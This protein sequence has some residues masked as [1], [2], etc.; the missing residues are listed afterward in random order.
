MT[1]KWFW[2][3]KG[4]KLAFNNHCL[5]R[6]T[7]QAKDVE[8]PCIRDPREAWHNSHK[9]WNIKKVLTSEIWWH[10]AREQ[11]VFFR[12]VHH[13]MEINDYRVKFIFQNGEWNRMSVDMIKVLRKGADLAFKSQRKM[14]PWWWWLHLLLPKAVYYPYLGGSNCPPEFEVSVLFAF[15]SFS[16]AT[17]KTC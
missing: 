4:V 14:P 16:S 6:C 3:C 11:L 1:L 7:K 9:H 17:E 8:S 2:T 12:S 15:S 10:N 5:S 13:T